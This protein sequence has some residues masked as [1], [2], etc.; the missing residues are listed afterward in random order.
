MNNKNAFRAF[1]KRYGMSVHGGGGDRP[2]QRGS[3]VRNSAPV[4][5]L[6][7]SALEG[8]PELPEN[9]LARLE[10][11]RGWSREVLAKLG[12]RFA[13]KGA[14]IGDNAEG[15]KAHLSEN[16]VAIPIRDEKGRLVNIRLYR[17]GG[18]AKGKVISWG[19][20]YGFARLWPA[21]KSQE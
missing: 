15:G 3:G 14:R 7:E 12:I 13:P 21:E 20:G 18:D 4:V 9:W 11:K 19:H 17:P 2:A 16:R 10:Q 5:L 1:K 6:S 8:L